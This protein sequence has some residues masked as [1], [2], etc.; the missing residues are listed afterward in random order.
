M[1][2]ALDLVALEMAA[3]MLRGMAND[4]E[5][6]FLVRNRLGD[7]MIP[8]WPS[9]RPPPDVLLDQMAR[10]ADRLDSLRCRFTP[11]RPPST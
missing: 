6:Q 3:K 4:P 11:D 7:L 8:A 2:D 1:L 5:Y 9:K 10:T